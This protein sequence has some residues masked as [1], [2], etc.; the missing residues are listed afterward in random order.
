MEEIVEYAGGQVIKCSNQ[1]YDLQTSNF[2]VNDWRIL[3]T[4]LFFS[5]HNMRDYVIEIPT[6]EFKATLEWKKSQSLF[7]QTFKKSF[8][9]IVA[10]QSTQKDSTG[11][12]YLILQLFSRAEVN[13][14]EIKIFLNRDLADSFFK[15]LTENFTML[16]IQAIMKIGDSKST[17]N[18][19]F[20]L[21]RFIDTGKWIVGFS[22]FKTI[23]GFENLRDSDIIKKFIEPAIHTLQTKIPTIYSNLRYE[24]EA[25][26]NNKK[27]KR[28]LLI[29]YYQ[30]PMMIQSKIQKKD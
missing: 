21:Q 6:D 29:F 24:F 4:I 30:N 11:E 15:E 14:K 17:I 5:Q 9:K 27:N 20:R 3:F 8:E 7:L 19:F 26:Q 10:L 25:S 1:F 28:N 22:D 18:L 13:A 16:S 2:G 23:F 12:N